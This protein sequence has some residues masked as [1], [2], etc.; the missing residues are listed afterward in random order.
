MAIA[1]YSMNGFLELLI[2]RDER[3]RVEAEGTV[4]VTAKAR[5]AV[6]VS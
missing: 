3:I 6:S 2:E 4:I 5:A 1:V